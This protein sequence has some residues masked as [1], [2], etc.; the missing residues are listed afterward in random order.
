MDKFMEQ[1][2]DYIRKKATELGWKIVKG[3]PDA[4]RMP[5]SFTH[6]EVTPI[7]ALTGDVPL[8]EWVVYIA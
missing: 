6:N 1:K 7:Y 4:S 2:I 8:P 3:K 5:G